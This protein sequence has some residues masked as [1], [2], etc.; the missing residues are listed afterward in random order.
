[1]KKAGQYFRIVEEFSRQSKGKMS[2]EDM[3]ECSRIIFEQ[4]ILNEDIGLKPAV[5][6]AVIEQESNFNPQA[7][8]EKSAYGIM[9]IIRMTATPYLRDMGLEWSK[10]IILDPVVNTRIGINHLID[11]HK[12]WMSEG[13]EKRNEW[14]LTYHAY[15]WGEPNTRLLLTAKIRTNVPGFKYPA[16]VSIKENKWTARGL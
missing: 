5:V 9:Q 11:L 2:I 3:I 16:E 1:M 6:F 4:S 14:H 15:F 8:S 7:I 10:N 12:M 13:L